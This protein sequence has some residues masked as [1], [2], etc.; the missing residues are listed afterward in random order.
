MITNLPDYKIECNCIPSL[1]THLS[2]Q[3]FLFR[4]HRRFYGSFHVA[5]SISCVCSFPCSSMY[6]PQYGH[7]SPDMLSSL[8]SN[9]HPTHTYFVIY[10]P[11]NLQSQNYHSILNVTIVFY[12][13]SRHQLSYAIIYLYHKS[14]IYFEWGVFLYEYHSI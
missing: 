1:S 12:L 2:H 14:L 6:S 10:F 4:S 9:P 5:S 13:I 11:S 7:G 8:L 3:D